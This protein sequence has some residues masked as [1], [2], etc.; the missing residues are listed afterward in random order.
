MDPDAASQFQSAI[1]TASRIERLLSQVFG[2][3]GPG[4]GVKRKSVEHRMPPELP[5]LLDRIQRERNNLVHRENAILR[6]PESFDRAAKRAL[7]IL[8]G[9]KSLAQEDPVP[10][11]LNNVHHEIRLSGRL[12][13]RPQ[14]SQEHGDDDLKWILRQADSEHVILACRSTLEAL[15]VVESQN[16]ALKLTAYSRHPSQ[17][18]RLVPRSDGSHVVMACE[19]NMCLDM[20]E[21]AGAYIVHLF[22]PHDGA[23][24]AWWIQ[25]SLR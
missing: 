11:S 10:F 8:E 6:D 15:T 25:P 12:T 22:E 5:K 23:N 24:Q 9:L 18:W 21:E 13:A 4:L 20:Y 2:A 16:F 3:D 7:E 17:I 1:Q 14:A 19:R